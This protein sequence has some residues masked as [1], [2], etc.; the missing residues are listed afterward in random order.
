MSVPRNI[1][2]S[3]LHQICVTKV[4]VSLPIVLPHPQDVQNFP[5]RPRTDKT[6]TGP[7]PDFVAPPT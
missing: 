3:V 5:N 4:P 2:L 6:G 1:E 7:M